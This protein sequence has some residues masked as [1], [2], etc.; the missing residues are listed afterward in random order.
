VRLLKHGESVRVEGEQLIAGHVDC[1]AAVVTS[2]RNIHEGKDENATSF[3]MLH[4]GGIL[5][6]N[7]GQFVL[8]SKMYFVAIGK[9]TV[10]AARGIV[11]DRERY[12]G[13]P[14]IGGPVERKGRLRYIDGCTDTVLVSPP[15]VGD[16][17]FNLLHFPRGVR[18]TMHTHPSLRCGITIS[19]YGRALFPD[20]EVPL[21]PGSCWF[22][23][24]GG[25]HAFHTD[26]AELLV[27]AWH[28]DTDT[29]PSHQDHPMLNRT[30]VDGV[31]AKHI[32]S[33][34]TKA[35]P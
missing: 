20:G 5:T 10:K 23:Q 8:Q 18:Q 33:I 26:D 13:L 32:E 11:V 24:T 12:I 25:Q 14:M 30:I 19:G 9:Y 35:A 3:G 21:E 4:D 29:G 34:R 6:T 27:S 28:P 16:P 22:L 1:G 15:V 17:C 7:A 31:S 2:I